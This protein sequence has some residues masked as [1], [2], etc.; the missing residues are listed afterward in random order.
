VSVAAASD[1]VTL[2]PPATSLAP[3]VDSV[4]GLVVHLIRA[5]AADVVVPAPV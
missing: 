1:H 5:A 2:S 4:V 3:A